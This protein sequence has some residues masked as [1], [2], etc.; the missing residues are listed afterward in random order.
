MRVRGTRTYDC[1]N[2]MAV[3]VNMGLLKI[4]RVGNNRDIF[5][6]SQ[7]SLCYDYLNRKIIFND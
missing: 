3:D 1:F 5:M 6:R 7:R 2:Y 4:V